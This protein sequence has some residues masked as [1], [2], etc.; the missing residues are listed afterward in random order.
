MKE[1]LGFAFLISFV[2][3][4]GCCSMI[5]P[6]QTYYYGNNT[7]GSLLPPPMPNLDATIIGCSTS[8]GLDGETTIIYVTVSNSGNAAAEN[9][10]ITFN[11]SDILV[12]PPKLELGL[13]PASKQIT[14]SRTLNTKFGVAT[15]VDISVDAKD[16]YTIRRFSSSDCKM[17]DDNTIETLNALV[18]SGLISLGK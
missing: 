1:L 18:H 2:I 7:S 10:A 14:V 5:S 11:A 16:T 15:D 3:F 12:S 13:L 17:L 8:Y 6:S 4:A 9:V